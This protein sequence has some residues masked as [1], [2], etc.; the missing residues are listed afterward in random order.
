MPPR[1][2][3]PRP[4]IRYLVPLHPEYPSR[5]RER[6]PVLDGPLAGVT[7]PVPRGAAGVRRRSPNVSRGDARTGP[8]DG[9]AHRGA[10]R[11][12]ARRGRLGGRLPPGAG[13]PTGGGPARERPARGGG[14]GARGPTD[15]A[16]RRADRSSPVLRVHPLIA[17]LAGSAGRLHGRRLP[18]QPVHLADLERSESARAGRPRLGPALGRLP[19]DRGRA[20]HQRGL[21]GQRRCLR[22]GAGGGRPPRA[23]DRL[24]ERPEP[25]RPH[26]RGADHRRSPGVRTDDSGGP[27][28]PPG[29]GGPRARC[30][31]RPHGRVPPHRGMR[32]RRCGQH[33]GD[34]P[35][36]SH[37]RL[38]RGRGNLAARGRRVRGAS[39]W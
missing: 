8:T 37:G 4:R 26:P 33:R 19:G 35:P 3:P 22:R 6:M 21:G 38:L 10:P 23:C 29:H 18:R 12:P 27:A 34:R 15:P 39:P 31:R 9:R 36:R 20:L 1:V 14:P 7:R 17:H 24:H 5:A 11:E 16:G 2:S 32:Q 25:Q 13:G 30:R 28:L